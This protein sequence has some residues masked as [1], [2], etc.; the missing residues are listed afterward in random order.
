MFNNFFFV[1]FL[2]Y[3][4]KYDGARGATNDITDFH[5]ITNRNIV[6]HLYNQLRMIKNKLKWFKIS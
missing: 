5:K 4:E 3:V 2:R 6:Y 1:P